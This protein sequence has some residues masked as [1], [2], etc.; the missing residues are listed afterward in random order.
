MHMKI[1]TCTKLYAKYT[2]NLDNFLIS[3]IIE[4]ITENKL[5][6][7]IQKIISKIFVQN[8]FKEEGFKFQ[9]HEITL[10]TYNLV[11]SF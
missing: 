8:M 7:R 2:S 10:D 11:L 4:N 3:L 6:D 9:E 1:K 5:K